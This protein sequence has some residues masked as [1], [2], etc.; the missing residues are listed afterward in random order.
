MTDGKPL[1]EAYDGVDEAVP[2]VLLAL[3]GPLT[4][5]LPAHDRAGPACIDEPDHN[6]ELVDVDDAIAFGGRLCRGCFERHLD[7]LARDPTSPVERVAGVEPVSHGEVT[8][9]VAKADGGRRPPLSSLTDR[10]ARVSGSSSVF[11]A[12]TAEGALC[13]AGV[14]T[15]VERDHLPAYRPCQDCFDVED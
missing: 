8:A 15:I 1:R 10:V 12:P 6:W 13:G 2:D 3:D 5:H 9:A 11:H 14:D 7:L 4:L